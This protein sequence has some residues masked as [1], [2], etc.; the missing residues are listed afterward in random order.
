MVELEDTGL[1]FAT[2][3]DLERL[4]ALAAEWLQV[5]GEDPGRE[6]LL[7]TPERVAKA[8]AFLTRGY[9]QRLEEVVGGAVFPAEGSDMVV[10]KG[11]EFYSMCEHHLLP[12]FGK[13]HI[14]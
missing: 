1:T 3:V 13:V 14:G 5:I 7:K 6:G 8:W 12:F 11:V 4:Q 2:E 9:R 10:V